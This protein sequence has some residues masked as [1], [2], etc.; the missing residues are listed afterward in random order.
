MRIDME[1]L[2]L[3]TL[4]LSASLVH[5]CCF[6][7]IPRQRFSIAC[8]ERQRIFHSTL[9]PRSSSL[10]FARWRCRVR[11]VL[12]KLYVSRCLDARNKARNGMKN[13][14]RQMI[15]RELSHRNVEKNVAPLN[16]SVI[17]IKPWKYLSFYMRNIPTLKFYLSKINVDL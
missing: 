8:G 1:I 10:P 15:G 4:I 3:A 11:D 12:S 16:T 17:F 6:P 14:R 7:R 2:Y 13:K 9:M 5:S